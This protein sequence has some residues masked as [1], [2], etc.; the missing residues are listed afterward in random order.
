MGIRWV[1]A[2]QAGIESRQ[3]N[4]NVEA[5]EMTTTHIEAMEKLGRIVDRV[6]GLY[7]ASCHE[8][9]MLEVSG[10]P[11]AKPGEKF[12]CGCCRKDAL[13]QSEA[14]EQA[15]MTTHCKPV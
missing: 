10:V 3:S 8:C 2:E 5:Q 1:D 14:G 7:K 11:L 4:Q 9:G 6:P 15:I 13:E 12:I